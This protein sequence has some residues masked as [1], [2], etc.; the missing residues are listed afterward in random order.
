MNLNRK[1][2]LSLPFRGTGGNK[3][4]ALLRLWTDKTGPHGI[5]SGNIAFTTLK[6]KMTGIIK[7]SDG[8]SVKKVVLASGYFIRWLRI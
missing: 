6:N 3:T 8:L 7:S 4:A 5:G 1:L 2:N